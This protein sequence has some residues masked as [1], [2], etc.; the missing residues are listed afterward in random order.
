MSLTFGGHQY[1]SHGSGRSVS[2]WVSLDSAYPKRGY[3]VTAHQFGLGILDR[4]EFPSQGFGVDLYV[5]VSALKLHVRRPGPIIVVEATGTFT[6]GAAYTMHQIPAYI[7]GVR[8]V[9]GSA[10]TKRLIPNGETAGAGQCKINFTTGVVTWGDSAITSA[11]I[12]YVPLGVPG[13][14]RDLLVVDEALTLADATGG[15][16]SATFAS[17]AACI[18]YIWNNEDNEVLAYQPVGENPGANQV[19]IDILSSADTVVRVLTSDIGNGANKLTANYIKYSAAMHARLMRWVD[20]GDIAMASNIAGPGTGSSAASTALDG[21]SMAIPCLGQCAPGEIS[22]NSNDL[23]FF[24]DPGGSAGNN[25]MVLDFATNKWTGN[26]TP[27]FTRVELPLLY[28]P[29]DMGANVLMDVGYGEDL[30][31]LVTIPY[32]AYG[33]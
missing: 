29:A 22:D 27:A 23:S 5:D 8:G 7:L 32:V 19:D 15:Y 21:P 24:V 20:Q 10:G 9:A 17:R 1:Y 26:G 16:G 31:A 11:V 13:F 12:M 25:V 18:N 28:V 4:V 30:S 14:T 2:G 33:V 3:D 6:A